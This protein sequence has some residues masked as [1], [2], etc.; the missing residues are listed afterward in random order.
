M[1]DIQRRWAKGVGVGVVALWFVLQ[2]SAM[3]FHVGAG[4]TR[5]ISWAVLPPAWIGVTP[6]SYHRVVETAHA[7]VALGVAPTYQE[8][9]PLALGFVLR[10]IRLRDLLTIDAQDTRAL[11]NDDRDALVVAGVSLREQDRY[12][13]DPFSR[14]EAAT[15]LRDAKLSSQEMRMQNVLEKIDLGMPFSDIARYF[16]E[17]S[18]ALAGGD[19]GVFLVSDLPVWAQAAGGMAIDEVRSDFVGSDAFWVMKV[20]DKGGEGSDA[21]VHVR[22]IAINKPTIAAVLRAHAEEYP[23][24]LFVW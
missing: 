4:W 16:S 10:D 21:W 7:F 23:A 22:G 12:I 24:F 2:L 6:V 19:L 18:S 11:P 3:F 1:T 14:V 5:G 8:A 15:S 13:L 17:D 20:V 9:F